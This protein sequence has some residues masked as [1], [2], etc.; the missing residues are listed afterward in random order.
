MAIYRINRTTMTR[1]L[2]NEVLDVNNEFEDYETLPD[3]IYGLT[4][5]F[6]D[7][8]DVLHNS[9]TQLVSAELGTGRGSS[10]LSYTHD[11]QTTLVRASILELNI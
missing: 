7:A 2:T 6:H 3:A 5:L 1:G 8:L 4:S 10:E 11:G 9:N